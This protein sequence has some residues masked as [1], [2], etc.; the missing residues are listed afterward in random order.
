M[1]IINKKRLI[2]CGF[3]LAVFA[4]L[5]GICGCSE[6]RKP[7]IEV[8]L[9]NLDVYENYTKQVQ[10]LVPDVTIKWVKGQRDLDYYKQL[11][12]TDSLP[13]IITVRK[14][15]MK[16]SLSLNPYLL[17]LTR[18]E[19][20]SSYYDIYLEN[21]KTREG[22]VFW[23]PMSGTVDGIVANKELFE[24]YNIPVPSDFESFISA[25][26]EFE[27][28]G[29]RGYSLDLSLDYNALHL[30]QGMGIESLSSVDG[31]V[32]RKDYEEGKTNHLDS[33]VWLPAFEKMERLN[34]LK[35]L[36]KDTMYSDDVGSYERFMEGTQAMVNISS[37][38]ISKLLPGKDLEILPYFG[39]D[40]D[41]LLTYPT[42]NA[43]VSKGVEESSEKEKAAWK[44]LMAMTSSQAQE[45][46]NQYTDGLISYKR[47]I[48][49]EYD[50]SM[51]MV[52][53]YLEKNRT[54][55]RL[56][57]EEFFENS[58]IT[59]DEM[60]VNHMSAE[61]ALELMDDLMSSSE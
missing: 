21:Y 13:D 49:F 30:L 59:V 1:K 60:L 12:E 16:D 14:F 61:S 26:Q 40:Q 24:Q 17:D 52:Q 31:M 45:V 42:F 58:R 22:K 36:D 53:R 50:G 48:S 23:V 9:W 56:G 28:H 33:K 41:F 34:T 18:T 2:G 54:Y 11:S 5:P 47:D 51:S 19:I 27:K 57:S 7:E 29:I 55:I 20:A 37:E 46:L 35:I 4:G 25:C 10:S 43:A 8:A 39:E 44:V 6:S 15:S 32:W 3:A 38:S